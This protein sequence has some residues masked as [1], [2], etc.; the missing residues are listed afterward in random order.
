MS[1]SEHESLKEQKRHGDGMMPIALY[2]VIHESPGNILPH[3]WHDEFEFIYL[4]EGQA[5]F[6]LDE[7]TIPVRAGE[8]IFVNSGRIHS[9]VSKG[10]RTYYLSVVC[11][12]E[13]LKSSFDS[14]RAYFDGILSKDYSV[15][16]HFQPGN[17]DHEEILADL[18]AVI[19]ELTEKE[20]AYELALKARL[21][22]LFS[23]VFRNHLYVAASATKENACRSKKYDSLKSILGYITRNYNRKITLSDIGRSVGL[24]PQYL[25]KLFREMT[26]YHITD[27]I[28][29][30]RVEAAGMLLRDTGS[31]ITDIALECGFENISYFNRI[32]KKQTGS[33]PSAFRQSIQS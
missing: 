9:G 24:T 10:A 22:S 18:K 33:T 25:C 11:S 17:P 1:V 14:S 4:A 6:S 30:Y 15:L 21:F 23:I 20:T 3:H 31:S 7:E 5:E 19:R 8:C 26:G 28:N 32:F 16:P 13:L 2:P 27:Y 12:P 29:R